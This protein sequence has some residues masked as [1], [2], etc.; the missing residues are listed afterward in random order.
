[1]NQ[2]LN[3]DDLRYSQ[4]RR[5]SGHFVTEYPHKD[6]WPK[7]DAIMKWFSIIRTFESLVKDNNKKVIDLGSGEAPVCHY[8]S[9]LGN[10]VI[11]VDIKDVNHLVNQSLV[12]MVLKDAWL[13]LDEQEEESVDVFVD[14]CAVTHFLDYDNPYVGHWSRTFDGVYK[15]LKPGGY[16]IITS[17]VRPGKDSG[18]FISPQKIIEYGIKSGLKLYDEPKYDEEPYIPHDNP[19]PIYHFVFIK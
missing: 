8:I 14:S 7:S 16:F 13:F 10:D 5:D 9:S 6:L 2:Y 15:A 3:E 19:Y 12:K 18:E 4:D 1:M 17:D 11:G